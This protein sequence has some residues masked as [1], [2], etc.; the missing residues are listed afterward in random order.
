MKSRIK[1]RNKT[2]KKAKK[3][4]FKIDSSSQIDKKQS[5]ML[6][7]ILAPLLGCHQQLLLDHLRRRWSFGI[8]SELDVSDAL[9]NDF[10]ILDKGDN[11]H[12]AP[13]LWTDKRVYLIDFFIISTQPLLGTN[14]VSS[15]MIGG[16]EGSTPALRILPLC[17]FE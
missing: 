1:Q 16:R 14:G 8:K 7:E 13:T 12:P 2:T 6:S 3:V 15:S 11:P 10:M 9:I 17:A 5:R 4:S